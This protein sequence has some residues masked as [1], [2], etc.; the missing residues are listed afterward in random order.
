MSDFRVDIF[1]IFLILEYG[2]EH[3][4][5]DGKT[6]GQNGPQVPSGLILEKINFLD[7]NL[8]LLF[9]LRALSSDDVYS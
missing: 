9:V 5:N 7:E 2:Q 6:F 1:T 3:H 4:K 8:L